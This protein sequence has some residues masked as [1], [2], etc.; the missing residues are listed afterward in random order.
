MVRFIRF[1]ILILQTKGYAIQK[2]IKCDIVIISVLIAILIV[3]ET[4]PFFVVLKK[5]MNC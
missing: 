4:I 1:F 3:N 5:L 2:A